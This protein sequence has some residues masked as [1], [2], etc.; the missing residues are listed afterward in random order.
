MN[1]IEKLI[2]QNENRKLEFKQILPK[3]DKI[4]KTAIQSWCSTD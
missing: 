3:K 2:S 1:D 4:I